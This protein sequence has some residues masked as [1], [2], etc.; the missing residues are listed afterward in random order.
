M[1]ALVYQTA[2]TNNHISNMDFIS[3]NPGLHRISEEILMTL[4]P[5]D[6][7]KCKQVNSTWKEIC[8]NPMFW[9]KKCVQHGN[10]PKEIEIKWSKLIQSLKNPKTQRTCNI[11]T[12]GIDWALY[13][14][15]GH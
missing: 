4:D 1:R 13:E 10:C 14:G 9:L 6:L 2:S 5:Q 15:G 8:N 3:K 12:N 7:L 11:S